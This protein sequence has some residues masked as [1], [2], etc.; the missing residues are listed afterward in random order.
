MLMPIQRD[1][2]YTVVNVQEKSLIRATQQECA[3]AYLSNEIMDKDI[4][5]DLILL[6]TAE[7]HHN[8]KLQIEDLDLVNFFKF[9][10][11]F[12]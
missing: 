8:F 11:I 3:Q 4:Y 2:I 1:Y 12:Y 5:A 7:E 10:V 6:V 9:S